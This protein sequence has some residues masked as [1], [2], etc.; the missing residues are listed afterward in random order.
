VDSVGNNRG[1]VDGVSHNR[2]G[3]DSVSHGVDG[4]VGNWVNSMVSDR[5]N[6]VERGDSSLASWHDLVG[7]N[8]GLDL[9][10]T[11][12]VVHLAH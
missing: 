4:V 7:S 8:G 6:G 10:Q 9:R 11:L 2:G 3:V 1:S 5:G 12:G